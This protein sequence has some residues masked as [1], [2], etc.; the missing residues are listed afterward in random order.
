MPLKKLKSLDNELEKIDSEYVD[1]NVP[2]DS[3]NEK[4]INNMKKDGIS[5]EDIQEAS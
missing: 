5:F 1:V 3:E 4:E 2:K